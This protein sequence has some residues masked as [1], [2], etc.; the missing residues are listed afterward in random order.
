[1]IPQILGIDPGTKKIGLAVVEGV[2]KPTLIYVDV[3][4]G[5]TQLN[6]LYNLSLKISYIGLNYNITEIVIEGQTYYI[7][8]QKKKSKPEDLIKLA[9]MAG[10]AAANCIHTFGAS[11]DIVVPFPREWKGN[12]PKSI[13]QDRIL[14]K[15]RIPIARRMKTGCPVPDV[16]TGMHCKNMCMVNDGDWFDILDA[17]GLALWRIEGHAYN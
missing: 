8:E 2:A 7:E 10:G 12:V 14:H 11:L 4:K 15:L 16:N 9:F 5:I 1:M 3:A 6:T 17:V 13:K